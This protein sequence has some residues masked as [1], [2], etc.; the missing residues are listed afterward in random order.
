M[1]SLQA[2]C[3]ATL[4]IAF[5]SHASYVIQV[6][7]FADENG[8][9]DSKCS[10]REAVQA[11]N[12]L[13]PFG[14]CKAGSRDLTNVI[15]LAD[16]TYTLTHGELLVTHAL[17]IQG[18]DPFIETETDSITLA[19]P[20]RAAPSLQ[21]GSKIDGNFL[22]RL[23]NSAFY[24]AN[25]TLNNVILLNGKADIGGAI[26]AGGTV[27]TNNSLISNN[28]AT[29]AGG[30]VYLEGRSAVLSSVDSTWSKNTSPKGAVL[31]MSCIDDLQ[32]IA[33]D[34]ALIR[35]TMLNNGSVND[36]SIIDACSSIAFK[37]DTSTIAKN[38]AQNTGG[39][40]YFA[41]R[42]SNGSS[43][44]L[45]HATIVE[46][47]TAPAITYGNLTALVISSTVIAFNN[48]LGCAVQ[49]A[50][51]TKYTGSHN[52]F[53]GCATLAALDKNDGN[54]LSK[55][56]PLVPLADE[57]M[58]LGNYGGYTLTYLPK[59]TS[60]Y[61]LNTT[62]P[63]LDCLDH[64]D[65]RGSKTAD[66]CDIGSVEKR[67]A[68]AIS[69]ET[70]ILGN[71]DGTDRLAVA[72]ALA[73]DIP[74]ETDQTDDIR[75]AR[76]DF[77]KD[78]QGNYDDKAIS[79]TVGADK[80]QVIKPTETGGRPLIQFDNRGIIMSSDE[81]FTCKYKFTDSNGQLSTEGELLF[82]IDNK[83][84]IA[85]DDTFTL[86]SN[87]ARIL[88]DIVKND[89][90][91]ND[92]KYGGLCSTS[93]LK[94]NDGRYI[95]IVTSPEVGVI[96]AD[97]EGSCPDTNEANKYKCYGGNIYYRA[98]NTISPFNDTFTYV[99][100]DIDKNPSKEATVTIINQTGT[101]ENTSSGALGLFSLFALSGL[102]FYRR[103]RK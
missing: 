29:T 95:R 37:V 67:T 98:K 7:T 58:P 46:N 14:G 82:R 60:T 39:I 50:S 94:C 6:N 3:F 88:I 51:N 43:L 38:T 12:T 31:A 54:L 52:A 5:E 68:I 44:T 65:Q 64:L 13:Q 100:Y 69:I 48:G 35:T 92:G 71:N 97:K 36:R 26:L 20:K 62:V 47:E 76:G 84:P 73:N 40:L 75:N 11:V 19:K 45:E 33:R 32:P 66:N 78:A 27:T 57:L 93:D 24:K 49:G 22:S 16:G 53:Q 34:S 74:S 90:D 101:N 18:I 80:C 91:K 79:I 28:R 42:M 72:D 87:T 63:T 83:Q 17:T 102:A 2:L 59:S 21:M 9:N 89:S 86:P 8:E 30:A 56:F 77:A 103:F 99:V 4:F 55:Q 41:D 25:I 23:F 85:V 96:E 61:L 81:P 70:Q 15:Q 10:L 1:R